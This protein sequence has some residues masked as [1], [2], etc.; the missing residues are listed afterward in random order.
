[1]A[2][3]GKVVLPVGIDERERLRQRL[4]RLVMIEHDHVEAEPRRLLERLV[5][6]RAAIDGDDELRAACAAKPAIASAFGP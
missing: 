2:E 5:A 6:H 1:M 4:G 3:A